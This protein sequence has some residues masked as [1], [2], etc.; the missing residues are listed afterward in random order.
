MIAAAAYGLIAYLVGNYMFSNYLQLHFVPGVG[1]LAVFC[2]AMI[3]AGWA[4]S[5]TTP[6]R[7]RSSWATPARW[8]WAA[9]SGAVAVC[10][11]R[12]RS[13]WASSAACSSPRPCRSMIQ[14]AYFKKTGKRIFL[15]A[16]IHHHF[17]KLGWSESPWSSASGSS[18]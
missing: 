10:A 9:R 11:T 6:R 14:V 2:G 17:E 1:E 12:M 3:G 5:G 4:S 13:C 16:P 7:P 18:R 8:P 15:M